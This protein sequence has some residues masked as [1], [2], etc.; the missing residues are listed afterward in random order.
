MPLSHRSLYLIQSAGVKM[1]LDEW[2]AIATSTG[3]HRDESKFY[4]G[5]EPSLSLLVIQARQWI[6]S[7]A[8]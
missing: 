3:T 5:S 8:E 2:T 4:N 7:R 6:L 1:S